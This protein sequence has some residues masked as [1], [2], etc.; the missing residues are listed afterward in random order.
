MYFVCNFADGASREAITLCKFR[1]N[2]KMSFHSD[3]PRQV[4]G[5]QDLEKTQELF[6]GKSIFFWYLLVYAAL[7]YSVKNNSEVFCCQRIQPAF[8][9]AS[10]LL[11]GMF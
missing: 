7:F 6:L 2:L 10:P 5:V 11:N 8:T 1:M 3:E 9:Y 4:G